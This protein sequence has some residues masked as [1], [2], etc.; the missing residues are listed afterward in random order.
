MNRTLKRPMFR[1]GGPVNQGSGIMSHVEPR[2]VHRAI[3]GR[4][5][6]ANGP[7]PYAKNWLDIFGSNASEG[8]AGMSTTRP[9]NVAS[10]INSAADIEALTGT[11][12]P[13]QNLSKYESA[14]NARN[15]LLNKVRAGKYIPAVAGAAETAAGTLGLA[16]W[17]PSALA[18][19]PFYGMAN[20]APLTGEEKT[21][22]DIAN[23][24]NEEYYGKARRDVMSNVMAGKKSEAVSPYKDSYNFTPTQLES[25][26]KN[27]YVSNNNDYNSAINAMEGP[28]RPAAVEKK[29]P[30]YT[31]TTKTDPK[32]EIRKDAALLK[33]LLHGEDYQDMTKGEVALVL[34][35]ALA[36][37]GPIG[38]KLK[39]ASELSIPLIK[40]KKGEDKE[41]VLEA[42]KAYREREKAEITA[43]KQGVLEKDARALT[44]AYINANQKI[45]P[46]TKTPEGRAQIY[47]DMLS[48]RMGD[49]KPIEKI[50]QMDYV[51]LLPQIRSR[52]NAIEA[53]QQK[54]AE[55]GKLS[56][57]E[58]KILR[59][60]I[61]FINKI[62]DTYPDY[63]RSTIKGNFKTG[64]RVSFAD[65][66]PDPEDQ[67]TAT[68]DNTTTEDTV[69]STTTS[70][71]AGT[72]QSQLKPV[73]KLSFEELRSRLPKEIT[74]DI[75][76][77]IASSEQA[78]QDFAYIKT[79]QDVNNFNVK[80]GVN[81][82]LPS[83]R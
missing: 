64:G 39:V 35:R 49:E 41:S 44:A 38:N 24:L 80:Y 14:V 70:A 78:L 48:K 16:A 3:G 73:I 69:E 50:K 63:F 54:I 25:K 61:T 12:S 43:G 1:I 20:A 52:T 40:A 77:L 83:N 58:E 71:D 23:K 9:T 56:K 74:N 28:D 13:T 51:N 65:G 66:T 62:K 19:A 2:R 7:D 18:I 60:N 11:G 10:S 79:Q 42:Y 53:S 46:R 30:E 55:G 34:A 67:D 37:P 6:F 57:D 82:V 26:G 15:N 32:A 45:D 72:Q 8:S 17:G 81:L 47:E 27:N 75:V 36:E 29:E 5:M 33:E 76:G 22:Q 68:T 59:D 4:A 21:K 31:D